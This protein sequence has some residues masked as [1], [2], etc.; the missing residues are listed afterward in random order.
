MTIE[1]SEASQSVI[2]IAMEM[3]EKYHPHLKEANI[4][5]VY[6]SEAAT[7]KGRKVLAQVS[8]FPIRLIPLLDEEYDFLIWVSK[9]DWEKVSDDIREAL[10]DHELCHCKGN[11]FAGWSI[12]GHDFEEFTQII[13]RHGF[14]NADLLQI[15]D[16]VEKY[17]Q[18]EFDRLSKNLLDAVDEEIHGKVE[19]IKL[20][21]AELEGAME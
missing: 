12:V 15:L 18:L 8:K 13:E 7:N 16:K 5:F 6:R 14:W 10:I 21:S 20:P 4:A 19:A 2:H 9:E 3:I 1:W 11:K 17:H